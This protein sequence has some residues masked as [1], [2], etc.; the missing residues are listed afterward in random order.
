MK[1]FLPTLAAT[2]L[3]YAAYAQ[4]TLKVKT[5]DVFSDSAA[6]VKKEITLDKV[7]KW[8]DTA[9]MMV[10]CSNGKTYSLKQFTIT[11]THMKPL[12]VKGYGTGESGFP[13]LARKALDNLKPGDGVMLQEVIAVT[14][15]GKE[16]VLPSIVFSIK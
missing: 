3:M 10:K 1:R 2:L 14:K 12:M 9:P 13:V 11:Y 7:Q 4:D 8:V 16:V 6:F 15:D 5:C